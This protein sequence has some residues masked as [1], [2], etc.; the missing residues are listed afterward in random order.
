M[1]DSER[2]IKRKS[3]RASKHIKLKE[4]KNKYQGSS[5]I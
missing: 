4:N 3:K 5:E 1:F 2:P